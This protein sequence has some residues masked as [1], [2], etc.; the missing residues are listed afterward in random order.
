[1]VFP[2][3]GGGRKVP[4]GSEINVSLRRTSN[5]TGED[6]APQKGGKIALLS[7]APNEP[8]NPKETPG[9]RVQNPRAR[10][11]EHSPEK[12]VQKKKPWKNLK[13]G[14]FQKRPM[15]KAK[16]TGRIRGGL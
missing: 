1:L 5:R 9:R 6:L 12:G 11:Q 8:P 16:V 15:R 4:C 7:G 13:K 14:L 3:P 10:R 2:G